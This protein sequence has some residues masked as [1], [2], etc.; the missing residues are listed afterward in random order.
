MDAAIKENIGALFYQYLDNEP[1]SGIFILY[2][3]DTIY[4]LFSGISKEK[5]NLTNNELVHA[6]VLKQPNYLGKH[7]DF[8]GANTKHLEQFK[9]SFGGELQPYY[10]INFKSNKTISSLFYARS[11]FHLAKRKFK[12]FY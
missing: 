2:D 1:I 4:A 6:F 10:K 3:D 9:R 5:R 7:F 11:K 8:L 12:S